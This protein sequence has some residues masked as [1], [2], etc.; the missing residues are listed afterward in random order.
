MA[1]GQASPMTGLITVK[2]VIALLL[3]SVFQAVSMAQTPELNKPPSLAFTHVT[4]INV[5]NGTL[6]RDMT[7]VVTGNRIADVGKSERLRVPAKATVINGRGEFLIPGLWDMHVHIE[8]APELF[9]RLYLAHGVTG[10]R[11]MRMELDSLLQLREKI[12][13]GTILMPRLV[14]SGPAL[15]NLPPEYPLPLKIRVKNA[16]DARKAVILLKANGVDFIKVHNF[17]PRDA[18]FAIA[19][20]TKQQQLTF[21]GHVPLSVSIQE[22]VEAGQRSIEHLSEFRV[23]EECS[24]SAK[25]KDLIALFKKHDTWQTPTLVELGEEVQLDTADELRSKYVPPSVK[26]FWNLTEGMLQNLTEEQKTHLK[27]Q[28]K[29]ALPLV[30]KFQ[31]Q[32]IGILAGTDSP[33]FANVVSGFSLHDELSLMVEAGLTPLEALQTATL[34]PARFLGRLDDLGTVEKGKLAD[35]VLLDA[36]PLDDIHNTNK[37]CAVVGDGRFLDRKALDRLLS[38]AETAAKTR[39]KEHD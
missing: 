6:Q 24:D 38:E 14:A 33:V 31:S 32:G 13:R 22:A 21:V 36:N 29:Q 28:Y 1:I 17:T 27:E 20:E 9:A 19:E 11:D 3:V 30:G 39:D 7:V 12:R 10:I 8:P 23:V 18:F 25:C 16:D 4:A 5:S 35:L 37:I 15:D 26:K 34:N 2:T